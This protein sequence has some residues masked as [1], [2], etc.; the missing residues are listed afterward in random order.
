MTNE[1]T[2]RR[3]EES[4]YLTVA[5]SASLARVARSTIRRWIHRGFLPAHRPGKRLL[6]ERTLL[7]AFIECTRGGSK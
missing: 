7:T 5:E 4:P 3:V 1:R 6:V 2:P